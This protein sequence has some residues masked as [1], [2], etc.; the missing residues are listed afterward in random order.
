ML[1]YQFGPFQAYYETARYREVVALTDATIRTTSSVEEIYYWK[2]MG[3]KAQ[4]DV[5]GAQQAWQRAL[6][7]NPNYAEVAAVLADL[8]SQP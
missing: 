8:G 7:L 3:L 1:W 5:A 4:G 2:G 6:E